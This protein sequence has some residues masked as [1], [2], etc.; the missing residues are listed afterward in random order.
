MILKT[1]YL[2]LVFLL[3][4]TLKNTKM[5]LP[6]SF[7]PYY[8]LKPNASAVDILV[9]GGTN[10]LTAGQIG[11][12]PTPIETGIMATA[13]TTA[14]GAPVVIG[15]GSWHTKDV[16]APNWG[17]LQAPEYTQIID[18]T[19]V[20]L[21]EK[22]V[23]VA[24]QQQISVFGWDE[25]VTGSTASV[26]PTF[27]CGTAYNFQLVLNGNPALQFLNH[28]LYKTF[29]AVGGCCGTDC[30]SGCTSTYV[31][32]A[33]IMLQWKDG[34]NQ[35]PYWPSFVIPRVYVN[36]S[37]TKTEVFSAYDTAQG[38]GSGTYVC[39]TANPSSIIAGIEIEVAYTPTVFGDCS[40]SPTDYVE[41]IPLTV[42]G[43]LQTQD[44][45]QCAVNTTLNTTVPNMWTE[46]QAARQVRGLGEQVVRNILEWAGHRQEFYPDSNWFGSTRQ[47]EIE[48]F[49]QLADVSRSG[50]YDSYMIRFNQTRNYNESNNYSQSK[51][52]L[53]FYAPTGTSTTAL[54]TFINSSLAAVG[55]SVRVRTI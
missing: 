3:Q 14:T 28:Q 25:S 32:A 23:A 18:W 49:T 46:L 7:Q 41:I 54:T 10:T 35:D 37:G 55:N 27:F 33:C 38:R 16:L 2:Y 1:A 21:V 11:F 48:N 17:G 42:V 52:S 43:S 24:G 19:K 20:S 47:R 30:T 4:L 39:N 8:L 40:F 50:L 22:S 44:A 31:D 51:Y 5:A 15:V 12:F 6:D 45:S 26:G 29:S 13:T 9:S 53:T 36:V 34:I